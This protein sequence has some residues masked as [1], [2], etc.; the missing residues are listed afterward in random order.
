MS[1]S[2][3]LSSISFL[4]FNWDCDIGI[5]VLGCMKTTAGVVVVSCSDDD[6]YFVRLDTSLLFLLAGM[7]FEEHRPELLLL[8]VVLLHTLFLLLGSRFSFLLY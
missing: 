6:E 1:S 5:D 3:S 7:P 8:L 2:V 4:R